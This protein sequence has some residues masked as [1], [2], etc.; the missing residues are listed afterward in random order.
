MTAK[1]GGKIK[2]ALAAVAAV[3]SC[4]GMRLFI[5]SGIADHMLFRTPFAFFDYDKPAAL[6][7]A[8][9]LAIL[10]FFAFIGG[11]CARVLRKSR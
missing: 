2:T 11:A 5:R 8:E 9:N 6:V 10:T 1:L 3:I 4:A 7:F